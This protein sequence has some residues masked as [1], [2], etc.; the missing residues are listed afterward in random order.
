M[1]LLRLWLAATTIFLAGVLVWAFAP[2]LL[3]VLLL[4]GGLGIV[5]AGMIGIARAFEAWRA[6]RSGRQAS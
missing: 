3:F 6:R 5:S 2:V 4:V 1:T